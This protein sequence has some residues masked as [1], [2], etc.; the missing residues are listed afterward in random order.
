MP[1]QGAGSGGLQISSGDIEAWHGANK[2]ARPSPALSNTR[3]QPDLNRQ[4]L[5]NVADTSPLRF[6][7]L[8]LLN[9]TTYSLLNNDGGTT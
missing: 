5:A 4:P 7:F 3:R 2:M 9:V 8:P 6:V 1:P